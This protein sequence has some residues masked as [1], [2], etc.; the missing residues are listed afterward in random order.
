MD[1][2]ARIL[3][4]QTGLALADSENA[5]LFSIQEAATGVYVGVMH[6]EFI[7]FM[8]GA[9]SCLWSLKDA[10][11][12]IATFEVSLLCRSRCER[13]R[14]R[15]HGKWNGLSDRPCLLHSWPHGPLRQYPHSLFFFPCIHPLGGRGAQEW[16]VQGCGFRWS[17]SDPPA[18]H[19]GRHLPIAGACVACLYI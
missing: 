19:H 1:P 8:S 16:G 2:Q 6:M 7:Q 15:G 14:K 18:G 11:S 3:L 5:R 12:C 17:L 9:F 4:E 13:H 10:F